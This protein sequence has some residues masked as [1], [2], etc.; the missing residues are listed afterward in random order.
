MWERVH[1]L[2]LWFIIIVRFLTFFLNPIFM[3]VQSQ[4]G[5]N[6][7]RIGGSLRGNVARGSGEESSFG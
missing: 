2:P 3:I 6:K 4:Q 5:E 7:V 1:N